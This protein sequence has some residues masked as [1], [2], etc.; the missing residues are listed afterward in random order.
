MGHETIEVWRVGQRPR[1]SLGS[2][3]MP[4]PDGWLEWRASAVVKELGLVWLEQRLR[5]NFWAG[6]QVQ[7][8]KEKGEGDKYLLCHKSFLF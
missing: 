4:S 3:C 8:T 6:P 1:A 2:F 5:E 7:E